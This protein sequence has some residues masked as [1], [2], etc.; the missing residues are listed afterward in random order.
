[1]GE[2]AELRELSGFT[3]NPTQL[4]RIEQIACRNWA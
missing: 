2:H 4:R 3:R 1:M